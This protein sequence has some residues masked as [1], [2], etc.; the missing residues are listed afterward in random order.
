MKRIAITLS[1]ALVMGLSVAIWT[2][3]ASAQLPARLWCGRCKVSGSDASAISDRP[4]IS[5]CQER[6]SA[7]LQGLP[8]WSRLPLLVG[9]F[10]GLNRMHQAES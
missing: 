6:A 3:D 9:S 4:R 1:I 7:C 5:G 8:I 2:S 10:R